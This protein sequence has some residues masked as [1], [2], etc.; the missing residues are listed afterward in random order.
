[1][2]TNR[3]SAIIKSQGKKSYKDIHQQQ[4]GDNNAK[5]DKSKDKNNNDISQTM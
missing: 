1:M 5:K 3:N 4:V 2:I